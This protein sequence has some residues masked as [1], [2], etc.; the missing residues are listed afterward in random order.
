MI[1]RTDQPYCWNEKWQRT[2]SVIRVIDSLK[3]NQIFNEV[4]D[5]YN[6]PTYVPDFVIATK[7]LIQKDSEGIFHLV[8]SDF[9]DRYNWS[10]RVADIFHL[11]KELLKPINSSEL[12][13]PE[14]RNNIKLNNNKLFQETGYRMLGVEE[15]L[16]KMAEEYFDL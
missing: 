16:K 13:L 7:K 1:L 5:W 3:K 11:K 14:K 15:G 8:G 2:N 9:I 4:I 6:S 10:L 12:K